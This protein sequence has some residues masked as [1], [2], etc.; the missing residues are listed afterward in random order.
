MTTDETLRQ[1]AE[2]TDGAGG[3]TDWYSPDFLAAFIDGDDA[4]VIPDADCLYIA[5]ASP[6]HILALLTDKARLTARVAEL[7]AALSVERIA[8]ALHGLCRM[9]TTQHAPDAHMDLAAALRDALLGTS[10]PTKETE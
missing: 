8:E 10:E 9:R 7:E 5:A 2:A 6:D 1:L 3:P 4:Q